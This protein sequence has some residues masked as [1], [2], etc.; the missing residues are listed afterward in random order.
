MSHHLPKRHY[1]FNRYSFRELYIIITFIYNYTE[2]TDT[3]I[4]ENLILLE[5]S[6]NVII[7]P[8]ASALFFIRLSAVYPHNIL[9]TSFFASSWL[10]IF[11][12]FIFDSATSI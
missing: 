2:Q 1:N 12:L 8:A 7:M 3:G 6:L 4:I 10:V 9:I 5:E 11:C